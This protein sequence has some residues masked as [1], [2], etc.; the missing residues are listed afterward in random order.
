MGRGG[1]PMLLLA[2]QLFQAF[3]SSNGFLPVT[4]GAVGINVLAFIQPRIGHFRWPKVQE[5]CVSTDAVWFDSDW[6]RLVLAAFFHLD[7]WHIYYNMASFVWKGISLEKDLGSGYFFSLLAIFVVLTNVVYC[8]LQYVAVLFFHDYSYLYSCAA[9]FSAVIFAVKVVTTYK[10]P[11]GTSYVM[12]M[13]PVPSRLAVWAE[14]LVISI[15][16]PNASFVGHL[17]GI[18]VGM[19]YVMGPLQSLVDYINGQFSNAVWYYY[20]IFSTQVGI[21]G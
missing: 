3:S 4:F 21:V 9:G 13:L 1:I 10:L 19:A 17:A 2:F 14:L 18:L 6:K 7:E 11:S 15:L 16:I 8:A 5:V 20:I 12:G